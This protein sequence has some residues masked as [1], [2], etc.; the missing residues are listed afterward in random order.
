MLNS[1]HFTDLFKLNEHLASQPNKE[2]K[3]VQGE[4]KP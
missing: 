1:S 4:V 2:E 3:L